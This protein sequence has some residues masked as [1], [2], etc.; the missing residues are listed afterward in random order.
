MK[1]TKQSSLHPIPIAS[2]RDFPFMK[3]GMHNVYLYCNCLCCCNLH[4]RSYLD[5][6]STSYHSYS[7]TTEEHEDEFQRKY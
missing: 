7:E 4:G 2:I 1:R 5:F 6:E 3:V